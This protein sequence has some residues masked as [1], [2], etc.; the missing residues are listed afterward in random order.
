MCRGEADRRWTD[1]TQ[2]ARLGF[3]HECVLSGV[4]EAVC[5][6]VQF[7]KEWSSY[8]SLR[9]RR[10]LV[11]CIFLRYI[12][13]SRASDT[14]HVFPLTRIVLDCFNFGECR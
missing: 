1:V 5:A 11:L 2:G 9:R 12:R 14:S 13:I 7:D 4:C 3:A 6:S 8:S 10:C